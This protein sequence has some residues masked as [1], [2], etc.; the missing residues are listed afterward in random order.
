VSDPAPKTALVVDDDPDI[1]K[2][3]TTYL[4]RLG[5]EVRQV[6]NGR[7]AIKRLEEYRPSLLCIDLV[8]P[9]SSGYD[10]CEHILK[11]EGLKGLPI[12]MISARTM[13]GDRAMAEEPGVKQYLF[14]PFTQAEFVE[15]V[16]K[17]VEGTLA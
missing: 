7:A 15:H 5:Y 3:I 17:T 16:K 13:P 2:I 10:V 8:L 11:S 12:L 14:K 6:G 1:R 9:G 4:K